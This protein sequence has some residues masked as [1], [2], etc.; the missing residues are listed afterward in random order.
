M[1]DPAPTDPRSLRR[2][3]FPVLR[4][5][6]TRWSDDDTYGHV[7]NVVHYLMF[8][9]A[10]NGWLIEA[11]GVDIR[12][13]PAI[14]LVVETS[15]QY[16]AELRFPETVTA[17]IALERLGTS[18]VVFRLALFGELSEAPAAAGRFVHVYV[19]DEHR[20]PT[21]VPPEIRRALAR[22]DPSVAP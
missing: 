1:T 3:D 12:R 17:G 6:P 11:S 13:L 4:S 22:L 20:R 8:D 15:C 14:G 18:S 5:L 10:V 16:F 9:T 7:N 19:D 2:A 21:P